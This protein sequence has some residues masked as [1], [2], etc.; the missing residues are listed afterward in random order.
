MMFVL[1][2]K[3]ESVWYGREVDIMM[4]RGDNGGKGVSKEVLWIVRMKC[5]G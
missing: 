3:F 4:W 5:L 2:G 1:V